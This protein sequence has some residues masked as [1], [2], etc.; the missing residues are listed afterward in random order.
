[1]K[2]KPSPKEQST[3]KKGTADLPALG[4]GVISFHTP[5]HE[6]RP[7]AEMIR[8]AFARDIYGQFWRLQEPQGSDGTWRMHYQAKIRSSAWQSKP[9]V[10]PTADLSVVQFLQGENKPKVVGA[11]FS[12]QIEVPRPASAEISSWLVTELDPDTFI[13][14]TSKAVRESQR[15]EKLGDNQLRVTSAQEDPSQVTLMSRKIS[16]IAL[17]RTESDSH[18]E[19]PLWR[20]FSLKDIKQTMTVEV[21]EAA[22]KPGEDDGV[23]SANVWAPDDLETPA[24]LTRCMNMLSGKVK[25]DP[26]FLDTSMLGATTSG[27]TGDMLPPPPRRGPGL[28]RTRSAATSSSSSVSGQTARPTDTETSTECSVSALGPPRSSSRCGPSS[29]A[30]P[31]PSTARPSS[32]TSGSQRRRHRRTRRTRISPPNQS[33]TATTRSSMD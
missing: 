18:F 1:M 8:S 10:R 11:T 12:I 26:D 28:T 32:R 19:G 23:R 7:V 21:L 27:N 6:W 30:Q 17:C 13:D 25:V 15:R 3:D 2:V 33:P 4:P 29:L 22:E 9:E 24:D 20:A 31:S 5:T 16:G 14:K